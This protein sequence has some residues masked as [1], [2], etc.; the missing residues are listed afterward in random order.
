MYRYYIKWQ[1][2][3]LKALS[4]HETGKRPKKPLYEY[5][6]GFFLIAHNNSNF[7]MIP[8]NQFFLD[9]TTMHMTYGLGILLNDDGY[10]PAEETGNLYTLRT[11]GKGVEIVSDKAE[12][13]VNEKL[14]RSYGKNLCYK[15]KGSRDGVLIYNSLMFPLGLLLP[16]IVKENKED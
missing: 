11:G 10:R 16:V 3:T 13:I 8:Q 1:Q 7:Y 2:E 4:E 9:V 12:V 14:L 15:I 5:K 6:D